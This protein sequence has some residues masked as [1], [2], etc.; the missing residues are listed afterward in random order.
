MLVLDLY[1][2]A[3]AGIGVSRVG[4]DDK[5]IEEIVQSF[6]LGLE[7]QKL[8]SVI[9]AG[10]LGRTAVMLLLKASRPVSWRMHSEPMNFSTRSFVS[11]SMSRPILASIS[12]CT[13][14]PM[15]SPESG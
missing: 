5:S 11:L 6:V 15:M 3:S 7:E 8:V 10:A 9:F 13:P 14:R 2:A 4:L 12:N 1:S